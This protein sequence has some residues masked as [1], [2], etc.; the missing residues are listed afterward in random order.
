MSDLSIAARSPVDGL[1][2]EPAIGLSA[3]PALSRLVLR[4]RDAALKQAEQVLGFQLPGHACRAVGSDGRHALWLG[5]DEWLLLAP[6]EE[7]LQGKLA[8]AMG[9]LPHSLVEVSHRQ[10]GLVLEGPKAADILSVGCPL[11]LDIAAFPT[12]MCTRTLVAKAEVVLWRT[13][14]TRFHI[15]VWRSFSAYLWQYLTLSGAE[16][17]P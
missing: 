7:K 13:S 9:D 5:P 2:A 14:D 10:L 1:A 6:P 3:A 16:F 15:E 4:G 11:D 8:F 12:G 17:V